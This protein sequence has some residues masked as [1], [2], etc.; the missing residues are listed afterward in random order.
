MVRKVLPYVLFCLFLWYMPELFLFSKNLTNYIFREATAVSTQRV[1]I[2]VVK[3]LPYLPV[4]YSVF[5]PGVKGVRVELHN[6]EK[7]FAISQL[8]DEYGT[9]V[10]EYIPTGTYTLNIGDEVEFKPEEIQEI[11]S[12]GNSIFGGSQ[13]HR[14]NLPTVTIDADV[15][16]SPIVLD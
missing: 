16:L 6:P 9:V 3:K 8:S 15:Y 11:Q 4:K 7:P 12:E 14:T 2:K 5:H 1:E 13:V 10:F